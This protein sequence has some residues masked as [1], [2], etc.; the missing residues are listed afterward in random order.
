MCRNEYIL[1]DRI[2]VLWV[3]CCLCFSFFVLSVLGSTIFF[4][5]VRI[6]VRFTLEE[7]FRVHPIL[8]LWHFLS[9]TFI[10][11]SHPPFYILFLQ[12]FY[13]QLLPYSLCFQLIPLSFKAI[14]IFPSFWLINIPLY[15]SIFSSV[16]IFS[17]ASE[18]V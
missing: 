9:S 8:T 17:P 16:F 5:Y 4:L 3:C 13:L 18:V 6:V 2:L 15:S 1:G 10:I 14:F 11:Y 7:D 12:H